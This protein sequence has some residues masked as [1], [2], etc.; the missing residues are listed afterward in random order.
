M[1]LFATDTDLVYNLVEGTLTG[2]IDGVSICSQAGSGGRAGSKTKG[3][4][5][6]YLANNPYATGVK[7]TASRPGGP[8]PHARY[9]PR[10]HEAHAF[11]IRLTPFAADGHLLGVRDGFAI[12][13]RGP[14]GSDGCIVLADFAVVKLL[15]RLVKQRE[16]T[17][18]PA[19]TLTVVSVGDLSRFDRMNTTA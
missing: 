14:W 5:N 19:P 9:C 15:H 4:I 18:A 7:K 2:T 11:W 12:H 6:P 1:P 16:D 8:I 13:G 17:G 10:T 3:A